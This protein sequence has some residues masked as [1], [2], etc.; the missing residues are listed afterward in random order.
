MLSQKLASLDKPVSLAEKEERK[1]RGKG[2]FMAAIG[3]SSRHSHASR[4]RTG[5][6][7]VAVVAT[8]IM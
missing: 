3:G 4:Q 7:S 6:T 2:W 8:T 5:R 1:Q